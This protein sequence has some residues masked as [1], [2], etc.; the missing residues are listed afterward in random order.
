MARSAPNDGHHA[1]LDRSAYGERADIL[2]LAALLALAPSLRGT[3]SGSGPGPSSA[4]AASSL[5]TCRT[6][7]DGVFAAGN[8]WRVIR[9]ISE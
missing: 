8:P 2:L 5:G 7:P 4:P 1:S 3:A 9:K 6:V